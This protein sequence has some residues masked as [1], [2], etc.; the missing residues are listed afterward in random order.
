LPT[1]VF[2]T[3]SKEVYNMNLEELGKLAIAAA[4]LTGALCELLL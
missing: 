2:G 1:F 3:A 4:E